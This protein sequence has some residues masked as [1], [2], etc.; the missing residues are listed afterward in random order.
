VRGIALS[1]VIALPTF[2]LPPFPSYYMNLTEGDEQPLVGREAFHVRLALVVDG[3]GAHLEGVI[4][5][6]HV[7]A[8]PCRWG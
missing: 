8:C 5:S 3:E 6:E 2:P 4:T 7:A 1:R